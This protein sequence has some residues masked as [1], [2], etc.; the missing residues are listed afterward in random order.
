MCWDLGF[1]QAA[2]V[3]LYDDTDYGYIPGMMLVRQSE[4]N[5]VLG[6]EII[7]GSYCLILPLDYVSH[8]MS[9]CYTVN[10]CSW[11]GFN[12][13]LPYVNTHAVGGGALFYFLLHFTST[14]LQ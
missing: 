3:C 1:V 2:M 12:T 6:A 8:D 7:V 9:V 4:R 13:K 14:E 5:A 10:I 11:D